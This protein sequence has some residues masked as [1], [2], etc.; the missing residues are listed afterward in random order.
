[1]LLH[2]IN[3]TQFK[4][5]NNVVGIQYEPKLRHRVTYDGEHVEIHRTRSLAVHTL[6]ARRDRPT[7]HVSSRAEH[8]AE[9]YGEYA[10]FSFICFLV[11]A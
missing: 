7:V 6:V 4:V 8:T 3:K 9:E 2:N 1:M 10:V 5:A 11:I